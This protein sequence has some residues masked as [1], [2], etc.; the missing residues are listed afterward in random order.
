MSDFYIDKRMYYHDTDAG[1]V[2]YYGAYLKHLEEARTEYFRSIGVDLV[3]YA[4]NGVLFP[5]VHIEVDYKCSA[6]Y[7]DLIRV[8]TRPEKVGNA[9]L[10]FTQEIKR[11]ETTLLKCKAVWACVNGNLKPT[12]I[13][14]DI[15]SKIGI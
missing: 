12:R 3:E 4:K 2:V 11:G 14:E 7:G 5:V 15:R 10:D 8:F 6:K 9:S 13:P 1:G